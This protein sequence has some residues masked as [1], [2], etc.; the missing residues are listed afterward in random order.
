MKTLKLAQEDSKHIHYRYE[1][2]Y[3]HEPLV[4][5]DRDLELVRF[6]PI[7]V[8]VPVDVQHCNDDGTYSYEH[9]TYKQERST[10]PSKDAFRFKCCNCGHI[11]NVSTKDYW[12][13]RCNE[14]GSDNI[15]FELTEKQSNM[16]LEFMK[17]Q[18]EKRKV[19]G[20]KVDA[21]YMTNTYTIVRGSVGDIVT[22]KDNYTGETIDLSCQEDW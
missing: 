10:D 1:C 9:K 11:N 8:E 6:E 13:H 16:A 2:E 21:M 15:R 20:K 14:D 4:L 12:S 5:E 18:E 19:M 22:L 17:Q 7:T 3:C